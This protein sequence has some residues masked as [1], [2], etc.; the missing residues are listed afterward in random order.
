MDTRA[1]ADAAHGAGGGTDAFAAQLELHGGHAG[2]A[3]VGVSNHG[4]LHATYQQR[5]HEL[6]RD[7]RVDAQRA[8]YRRP[9]SAPP[10]EALSAPSPSRGIVI[11]RRQL[12]PGSAPWGRRR[13]IVP[14]WDGS[15][16]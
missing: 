6:T 15:T 8:P 12:R 2:A 3:D 11:D 5:R 14:D 1:A 9:G 13:R 4:G 7:P 10:R 16:P